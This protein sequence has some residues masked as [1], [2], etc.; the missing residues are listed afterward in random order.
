MLLS[1]TK[2]VSSLIVAS[3]AIDQFTKQEAFMSYFN[4]PHSIERQDSY[5]VCT[6][7][8]RQWSL[9]P[10]MKDDCPNVPVYSNWKDVPAHLQ[11]E[12]GLRRNHLRR[13]GPP[14]SYVVSRRHG[15]ILWSLY[16]VNEAVPPRKLTL[17][18][19]IGIRDPSVRGWWICNG[20]GNA[21]PHPEKRTGGLCSA[22][23]AERSRLSGI[24]ES[25]WQ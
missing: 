1:V 14:R 22:C 15:F 25:Y 24:P 11:S 5:Y 7:C 17:K 16:D 12:S 2:H 21:F 4:K 18:Q 9:K 6:T 8:K 13:G 19:L 10:D 23:S 20:C 3:I